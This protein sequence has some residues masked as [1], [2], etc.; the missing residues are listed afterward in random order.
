MAPVQY[1][2][3]S[4]VVYWFWCF[5]W[6]HVFLCCCFPLAVA[7][8]VLLSWFDTSLR[9]CFLSSL[10]HTQTHT[11]CRQT[12]TYMEESTVPIPVPKVPAMTKL[13]HHLHRLTYRP[14]GRVYKPP[15]RGQHTR[16]SIIQ[17]VCVCLAMTTHLS[18]S[19]SELAPNLNRAM[20][21]DST[22]RSKEPQSLT[23]SDA[24]LAAGSRASERA[25]PCCPSLVLIL[26]W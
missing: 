5:G 16:Q 4:V 15:C 3:W 26:R 24:Q 20:S 21:R 22:M 10:V 14:C 18:P 11:C 19:G 17:T 25:F 1:T 9:N 23:H 2:Y 6:F 12:H 8:L 7:F 13:S